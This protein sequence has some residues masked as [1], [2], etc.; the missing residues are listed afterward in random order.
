MLAAVLAAGTACTV[1]CE[2]LDP[3]PPEAG[4]K[5]RFAF[6]ILHFA[7]LPHDHHLLNLPE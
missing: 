5:I 6:Y 1:S 2:I 7:L 3:H 4:I